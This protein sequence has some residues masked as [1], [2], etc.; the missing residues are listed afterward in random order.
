MDVRIDPEVSRVVVAGGPVQVHA[1][2]LGGVPR[3]AAA[4][5]AGP[6]GLSE[7]E[8]VDLMNSLAQHGYE[9]LLARPADDGTGDDRGRAVVHHLVD[10]LA[11]RGWTHEQTGVIGYGRGARAALVAGSDRT[12]GAAI[13]IPRDPSQLL[14]P[15]RVT[16]LR[17]PWL[18]LVG[19]GPQHDA[20]G[21][22]AAY[23]DEV[24]TASSEHTSLIGYP[25]VAHCLRDSTEALEHQAVFDAW[26]RTAEWL[27]IHV[28]PRPTPLARAWHERQRSLQPTPH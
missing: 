7:I 24:R 21:E 5:I 19:L 27:N 16:E 13:S 23:R 9:S 12:Y 22:L 2:L 11:A 10:Q 15:E 3:G 4:V 28:V 6:D 8:A 26:Q 18:C 25:G 17:T 14:T 1:L 20:S